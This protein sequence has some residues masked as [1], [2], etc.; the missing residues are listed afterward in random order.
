MASRQGYV[1]APLDAAHLYA[2]TTQ[3]HEPSRETLAAFAYT[4]G[5]EVSRDLVLLSAGASARVAY[6]GPLR[7]ASRVAQPWS[8]RVR[9]WVVAIGSLIVCGDARG[10]IKP[11]P[12]VF[13]NPPNQVQAFP[14]S[15]PHT[16]SRAFLLTFSC[17]SLFLLRLFFYRSFE[18]LF[19]QEIPDSFV[20]FCLIHLFK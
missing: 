18:H 3:R 15:T 8:L 9:A 12:D 5:I 7:S 10:G 20:Q 13:P 4:T 1:R 6:Y 19:A 2:N 14:H 16:S 17:R 11:R